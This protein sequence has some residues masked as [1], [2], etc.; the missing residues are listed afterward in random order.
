MAEKRVF[1][2]GAGLAGLST[3]WHLQKKGIICRVFEKEREAGGLCRSRNINGFTFDCDGHLLH[4]KHSYTFDLVKRLLKNNLAVY[5]RN[6][7][8]YS[9]GSYIK[10]PFQANLY[11]LPLPV[12]KEC[13]LGVIHASR[14]SRRSQRKERNFLEWVNKVFGR[15]IAKYFMVPYNNKFWTIPPEKLTSDWL[16]GVIPVP[17]LDQVIEGTLGVSSSHLGYN[18]RFY[19][20]KRGGI[21]QLAFALSKEI[22]NI[23]TDC[24]VAQ[25]DLAGRKI[26]TTNGDKEK[27]DWLISTLP[28]PALPGIIKNLPKNYK[29][30]FGKLKWNSIFNLNLGIQ[31]GR[32]TDK[33]WVYFP[34][35]EPSFFR[36]GFPH[37]FSSSVV[38][39][40][41]SSLYAEVAYSKN[42]P[43]EKNTIVSRI[44]RDLR[45]LKILS[46]EDKICAED[47]NQIEYGYPIYDAVYSR[48]RGRL[49]K[50]LS[51]NNIIA[52]GRYGSWC[53]MS[54]ED[55]IL[56]GRELA[57]N[58][59]A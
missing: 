23:Y 32:L 43:I 3:A 13:L 28:L 21:N 59:K 8:I 56:Q 50:F 57:D 5:Q 55:V 26:I 19:Y 24:G 11:N 36:V 52:C 51:G 15:G 17:T 25:I 34:D 30:L 7:W 39:E 33:H 48:A 54:M 42:R 18:A 1:V 40:G 44:K 4:F 47:I 14:D 49:L 58:F 6:A 12:I 22:K 45:K 53:Y 37:S 41:K 31:S 29:D 10:Y 46:A 20:P 27:F 35:K 38:P 2:L 16:C 9:G